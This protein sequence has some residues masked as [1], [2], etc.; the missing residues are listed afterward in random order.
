MSTS[1][2][3]QFR[4]LHSAEALLYFALKFQEC[5]QARRSEA[6]QK[7]EPP[8]PLE[9][10]HNSQVFGV[11]DSNNRML[12]GYVI[13]TMQPF[14]LLDFV[15]PESRATVIAQHQVLLDHCCE[16]TC[17]WRLPEINSVF[18][19]AR[20]WPH[21][22][23]QALKTGKRFFLGHNSHPKLDKLYT[24]AGPRTLYTGPSTYGL[25]SRVFVYNRLGLLWYTFCILV[26]ETPKRLWKQWRKPTKK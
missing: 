8:I 17:A 1:L 25:P 9:Y 19:S 4:R 12:A 24:Q 6:V 14:R 7:Q 18:M 23:F 20:F 13:G 26:L 22:H 5:K 15:P 11:F 21:A 10:L 16:A 2:N 3:L